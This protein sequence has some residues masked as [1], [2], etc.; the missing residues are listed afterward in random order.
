MT[1]SEPT[2]LIADDDP[3][4]IK[5]LCLLM[6]SVKLNVETYSSAQVLLDSD[7]P[8]QP[9]CL[10]IDMGSQNRLSV[11]TKKVCRENPNVYRGKTPVVFCSVVR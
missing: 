5:G 6:K 4:V 8:D 2:V 11:R 7:N 3:S 10:L 1:Q 9:S